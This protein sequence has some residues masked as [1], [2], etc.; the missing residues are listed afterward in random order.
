MTWIKTNEILYI[1]AM[2]STLV[3]ISMILF[4]FK[5]TIL[6]K[7]LFCYF[8]SSIILDSLTYYFYTFPKIDAYFLTP[9]YFLY[10]FGLISFFFYFSNFKKSLKTFIISGFIIGTISLII[11]SIYIG[12]FKGY[13][14][15]SWFGIQLYFILLALLVFN[16]EV[17]KIQ[18]SIFK[19]STF[20]ISAGLLLVSLFPLL[21]GLFQK[22][23]FE[24]SPDFFQ[25]SLMIVNVSNITANL[26]YAKGI[27]HLKPTSIPKL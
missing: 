27:F 16:N 19:N 4:K 25:F 6:H 5:N 3:P 9:F 24:T 11:R 18:K 13:D 1:V 17:S 8:F 21:S 26:I 12:G 14:E 20:L 2:A 7:I 23:I 15:K 22:Q 10:H